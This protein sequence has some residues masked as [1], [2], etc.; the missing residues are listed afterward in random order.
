[1]SNDSAVQ[2]TYRRLYYVGRGALDATA[3][4]AYACAV[5]HMD[6]PSFTAC[7]CGGAPLGYAAALRSRAAAAASTISAHFSPIM[8]QGALVLPLVSVGMI[9]ASA[10]RRPWMPC[11]LS[12]LIDDG[13]GIGAHLAGADRMV[14]R[15]GVVAHPVED[16]V[17][18]RE[19]GA[20]RD[21]L[22]RHLLER[23]GRHQ[24]AALADG[25]QEAVAV[26]AA[27]RKLKRMAGGSAGSADLTWT[28]PVL[29][30][31][32]TLTFMVMPRRLAMRRSW[33]TRS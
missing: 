4:T 11:T 16:L 13:H 9:E 33:P 5:G 8:M 3:F 2:D 22:A 30:E 17:V 31:R 1:M 15:L 28:E 32:S 20:R 14:G 29:S 24:L 6:R 25:G 7:Y 12:S 10:T 27:E 26:G 23:R 21:L 19:M 18:G